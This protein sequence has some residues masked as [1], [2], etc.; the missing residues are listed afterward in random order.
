MTSSRRPLLWAVLLVLL[1]GLPVGG[2]GIYWQQVAGRL[3]AGVDQWVADQRAAGSTVDFQWRG[4]TGFPFSFTADFTGVNIL[5]RL[6]GTALSARTDHLQLNMSPADLNAVRLL[7]DKPLTVIVPGLAVGQSDAN[8]STSGA[9]GARLAV[10]Q[11]D[12]MI[13][14]RDGN[15]IGATIDAS[16][17]QLDN[18]QDKLSVTSLH[19]NVQ[20]PAIQPHDFKDPAATVEF[21][22]SGVDLPAEV[23][24]LLPGPITQAGLT[25]VIKGP[26]LS[27]P[28]VEGPHDLAGILTHWRDSGGVLDLSKFDFAQGPLALTGAGTFALDGNL[29][30]MGASK[31]TA[32][33]LGDL[34]DLLTARGSIKRK[35][36]G[37]AKAVITGLQRPDA[38]GRQQV[39]LGLSIEDSVISFGA[40]KLV[41][42]PPISWPH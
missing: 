10:D 20:L 28:G 25:G 1:V 22:A 35:E 4:I 31:V 3:Q 12:G 26:L 29:Q 8:A 21:A 27:P 42:L 6:G 5:S 2:Y 11:A 17:G 24:Q 40:F 19:L 32:T 23:P 18:G 39:T 33:G 38:N 30:P 14:L 9:P 15:P 13:R 34:I 41:R 7:C 16:K 37:I 36:A